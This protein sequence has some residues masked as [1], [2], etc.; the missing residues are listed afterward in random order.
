MLQ[1]RRLTILIS[2]PQGITDPTQ[3]DNA[4]PY[5]PYIW[6][7]MKSYWEL[8][9]DGP[10]HEWLD[11]IWRH[12]PVED[13]L[14]GYSVESID[15]LGLSCYTWNWK[16]QCAIARYVKSRN[17][18]CYVVAGGPEP[19]YK[20]P[21]FF[22]EHPY[23]DAVAVKDGEITFTRLLTR[24]AGGE[25]DMA[26][27]V[28]LQLPGS[29]GRPVST[30]DA[31]VPA[32]FDHS[33]YVCQRRYYDRLLA[34]T[35]PGAFDAILETNRGCPYRCS[36]CDWGSNTMSKIR[37]FDIERIRTEIA[38]MGAM[39]VGSIMLA[40]ANFGILPRDVEI[41]ELM[42]EVRQS[43]GGFPQ[44][45]FWSAAKNH[46]ERVV[47]I[48]QSFAA[49]G[50]CT[51]HA[52]S[53]Q[54]TRE[55]VLEATD[56][57]NI[58]APRQVEVAKAM[59]A[60]GVPIE[61]QLILGIPGDTVELW[62]LC[63]T[64]LMEWGIHEDYLIQAYRLLPNAPAADISFR[65]RWEIDSV[66]RIM[67]DYIVRNKSA[68]ANLLEKPDRVVVS[69]KTFTRQDW[70]EM[71][72]YGALL[73]CFH[74]SSLIQRIAV[75]LRL[76][77]GVP[78]ID[79]YRAIVDDF[80]ASTPHTIRLRDEIV[81]HYQRFL[82]DPRMSDHMETGI[83]GLPYLLHPS[84]WL[85]V[86]ICRDIGTFFDALSG[87]LVG[88]YGDW[89]ELRDVI[90]Y[91]RDI[92]VLPSYDRHLGASFAVEFDWPAYFATARGR[93]G[94]ESLAEPRPLPGAR[95]VA[96]DWA[97]SERIV[98]ADGSVDG[99]YGRTFDWNALGGD[100][101]WARWIEQTVIDRS[102]SKL[103]N[104]CSLAVDATPLAMS[105]R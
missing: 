65:Q 42:N 57:K 21:A 72:L 36:F 99:Y 84:R 75:Y 32:V 5:L 4:K 89:P 76:T 14:A 24:L 1:S 59:M 15:V 22:A 77:H 85:F 64:D 62:R 93:Q 7:I 33:P 70:V 43:S 91:Q 73:K 47:S 23:I 66:D 63:L 82:V 83:P 35:E 61:V 90:A 69:S 98:R 28:G 52:L 12:Q 58:S 38:W 53:I 78:Y 19:D 27:V 103:N 3:F 46:P 97:S 88:R 41:A 54:H 8:H 30:G 49:S 51:V 81:E 86:Q 25:R 2:E 31:D 101:R 79:F 17:P 74:N 48:A 40:D 80:M 96:T 45:I 55:E 92:I 37:K 11:P 56:R 87:F 105:N 20:N 10:E 26:G 67:F 16:L 95:V 6:A 34:G 50:I 104:L 13:A 68:R 102:S 9:G 94:T 60:S 39:Q 71:A 18:D 100:A 29:D 44:H